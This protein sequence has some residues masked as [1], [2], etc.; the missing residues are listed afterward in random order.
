MMS[1]GVGKISVSSMEGAQAKTAFLGLLPVGAQGTGG[2]SQGRACS[3]LYS[4]RGV[5]RAW[6]LQGAAPLE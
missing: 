1:L 2:L 5:V 6:R 4:V 3:T